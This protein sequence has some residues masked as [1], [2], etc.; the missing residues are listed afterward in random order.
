MLRTAVPLYRM[1]TAQQAP[2]FHSWVGGLLANP[3][4]RDFRDY[5]V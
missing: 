1:S 3:K 2:G 5:Q 4:W